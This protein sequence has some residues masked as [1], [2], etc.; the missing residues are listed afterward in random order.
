MGYVAF[1]YEEEMSLAKSC[2]KIEESYFLPD[3]Q[4]TIQLIFKYSNV[5]STNKD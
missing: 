5:D 1:D 2:D 4:V 3:G